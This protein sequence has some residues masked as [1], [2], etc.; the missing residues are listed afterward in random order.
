MSDLRT[1]IAHL[2]AQPADA[3]DRDE[4]LSTF[5][6]F[7]DALESRFG[8]E[9]RVVLSRLRDRDAI[10]DSIKTFLGRGR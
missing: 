4:A 8:N 2:A 3:L 1:S 9:E 7:L 6:D 5:G 10:V